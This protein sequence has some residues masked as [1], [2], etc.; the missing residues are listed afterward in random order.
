[1]IIEDMENA[2]YHAAEGIS[3]SGLSLIAR[4]PAHYKFKPPS[5]ATRSMEMGTAIHT[6]ILE[7]ER[8]ASEYVLLKNIT[9]RRS[10]AYKDACKIHSSERVLTGTEADKVQGMAES[11]LGNPHAQALIAHSEARK[12]LSVFAQD[13]E[14]GVTVKCRFDLMT[15]G[16]ALDLKKTQ[17]VRPEAFAKSVANYRYMVQAAFYSDVWEWETGEKLDAFGFLCVEEE[18][19]HASAIYVLDDEAMDYGRKLYRRDLNRYAECV[20]SGHWPSIDSAPQVLALP[21]WIYKE[22]V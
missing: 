8:F 14:T 13:P 10:S 4:S 2:A 5:E 16:K 11:I 15:P 21:Q 20:E 3:N 18:M 19:P 12:E 22:A 9:D 7:P 17:D 6:A 1:M